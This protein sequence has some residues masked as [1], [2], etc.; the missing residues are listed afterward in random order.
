MERIKLIKQLVEITK[1][2][3]EA[4]KVEDVDTYIVLLDERELILEAIKN[5]DSEDKAHVKTQEEEMLITELIQLDNENRIVYDRLFEE[6]KNKL[7][8][9][10]LMKN[11]EAN[12][13]ELYSYTKE[14]GMLFDKRHR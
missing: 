3:Q 6:V 13:N 11:R 5:F 9:L 14:E 7:K 10:R 1:K 8:E 12:Y 2:Q 4:L